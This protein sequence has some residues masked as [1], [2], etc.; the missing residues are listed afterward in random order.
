MKGIDMK[1]II[2]VSILLIGVLLMTTSCSTTS[3]NIKKSSAR[4]TGDMAATILLDMKNDK[5][6]PDQVMKFSKQAS[7][8]VSSLQVDTIT[9]DELITLISNKVD[10]P[11]FNP[12]IIK[13]VNMIPVN[14]INVVQIKKMINSACIGLCVA[15][16]EW[17]DED[18]K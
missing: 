6:N 5:V 7:D 12:Y 9:K 15:A 4:A 10:N 13:I 17:K 1:K 2:A 3:M 8:A 14:T 16:S 18:S 11:V